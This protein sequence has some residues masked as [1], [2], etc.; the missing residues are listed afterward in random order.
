MK[1]KWVSGVAALAISVVGAVSA[2]TIAEIKSRSNELALALDAQNKNAEHLIKQQEQQR[3]FLETFAEHV[4]NGDL[5]YRRDFAFYVTTVATD[6][7]V[8]KSW[9]EYLGSIEREIVRAEA[10][11]Q[12]LSLEA[13]QLE[14]SQDAREIERLNREIAQLTREIEGGAD[15]RSAPLI[16]DQ[17]YLGGYL[18]FMDS[19]SLQ[20]FRP[21]EFL[22]GG[23]SSL[24]PNSPAFGK[25]GPPP[26]SLWPNVA[27]IAVVLD[28]FRKRHGASVQIVSAYRSP[29]YNATLAA[30]AR[31]SQHLTGGAVDFKSSKGTPSDWAKI[32]R[33]M[34]DEGIFSGGIGVNGG[35]VHVDVRGFNVDWG[36]PSQVSEGE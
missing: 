22:F 27:K 24:N 28:E 11:R 36:S 6:T 13:K 29:E 8:K 17:N 34:R 35:F 7:S 21:E 18:E 2:V 26:A 30:V 31:D 1:V 16:L 33:S 25:N 5:K 23:A 3:L 10:A 15:I 32:L 4:M 9:T 20:N 14:I 12:T 19:L